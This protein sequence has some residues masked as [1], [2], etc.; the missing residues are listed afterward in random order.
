MLGINSFCSIIFWSI[1]A[2]FLKRPPCKWWIGLGNVWLQ[3]DLK[4]ARWYHTDQMHL[5][6]RCSDLN[7]HRLFNATG[8][9]TRFNVSYYDIRRVVVLVYVMHTLRHMDFAM[10]K[11]PPNLVKLLDPARLFFD[12]PAVMVLFSKKA[13]WHI[14]SQKSNNYSQQKTTADCQGYLPKKN[15]PL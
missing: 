6:L 11:K 12:Y 10:G 14:P 9:N 4:N 3:N 15:N 7:L 2:G 1:S 13:P 5:T 8:Y